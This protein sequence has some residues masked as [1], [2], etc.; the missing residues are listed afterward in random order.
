M[1]SMSERKTGLARVL[2]GVRQVITRRV[3][4]H[5]LVNRKLDA[6]PL[7]PCSDRTRHATGNG[8]S[9]TATLELEHAD[10]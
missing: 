8:P 10:G 2:A 3:T 9:L 5:V 1:F 6:L 7:S 4:A